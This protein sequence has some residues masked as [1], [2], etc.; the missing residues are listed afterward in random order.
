MRDCLA[1]TSGSLSGGPTLSIT[2]TLSEYLV[3]DNERT[4]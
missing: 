2:G 4:Y 3:A 1:A